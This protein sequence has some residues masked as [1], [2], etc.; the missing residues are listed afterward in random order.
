MNR[1]AFVLVSAIACFAL[2]ACGGANSANGNGGSNS[3]HHNSAG[4]HSHEGEE[5][6]LGKKSAD[7]YDI[8]ATQ[9]GDPEAGGEL[10][11]EIKV[12][13]DG[14]PASDAKVACWIGDK[15]SKELAP[16]GTGAWAAEEEGFDCHTKLPKDLA[17]ATKFCLEIRDGDK[18]VSVN[19]DI[20]KE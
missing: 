3:A 15:D 4:G 9:I 14:K 12:M 1:F 19:F 20:V 8:E 10:V 11:F 5:H 7:G 17:G 16:R 6:D 13:K 18:E 2:A